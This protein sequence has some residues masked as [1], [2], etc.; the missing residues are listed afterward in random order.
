MEYI[1][2]LDPLQ[3]VVPAC[4]QVNFGGSV[5]GTVVLFQRDHGLANSVGSVLLVVR[6]GKCRRCL[7]DDLAH[8]LSTRLRL[9]GPYARGSSTRQR[10]SMTPLAAATPPLRGI[11][12]RVVGRHCFVSRGQIDAVRRYR[13]GWIDRE[14][15]LT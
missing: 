12:A 13:E 5:D 10:I 15:G 9:Y 8:R 1:N 11:P 7:L 2:A 6:Y 3:T 4:D 14:V